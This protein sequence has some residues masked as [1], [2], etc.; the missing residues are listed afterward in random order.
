MNEMDADVRKC[1]SSASILSF[2]RRFR[3]FRISLAFPW[4]P[5]RFNS[6]LQS[7]APLPAKA[8]SFGTTL[9][10][11]RARWLIADFTSG[12]SWPNVW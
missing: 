8:S 4:R 1:A 5:W 7:H 10:S 11:A 12:P 3:V 9:R 6:F 2:I